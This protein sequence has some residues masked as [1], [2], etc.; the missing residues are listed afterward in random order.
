MADKAINLMILA[1]F[2][3]AALLLMR[4]VYELVERALTWWVAQ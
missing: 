4:G 3:V 2:V 1:A